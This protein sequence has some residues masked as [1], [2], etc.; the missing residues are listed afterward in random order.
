MV[1]S[2]SSRYDKDRKEGRGRIVVVDDHRGK[3]RMGAKWED[4]DD[5]DGE[6]REKVKVQRGRKRPVRLWDILLCRV[7]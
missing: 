7:I 3:S 6:G 4:D 5:D 2:S 1:S